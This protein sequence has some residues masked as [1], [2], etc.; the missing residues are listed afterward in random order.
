MTLV[1]VLAVVI[2]LGLIA[3]TLVVGLGGRFGQARQEIAR[4]QIA[5]LRAQVELF[6]I[7]TK[8]LPSGSEGL[9]V[10]TRN[11]QSA[12]FIEPSQ[13]IDPW[14]N[15]L[16]YVVPGPDGRAFEIK[17]Y[18]ADGS[19]GGEGENADISSAA[20]AASNDP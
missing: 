11:P 8:R 5:S 9:E 1:E 6:Q 15:P 14:G 19:V 13:I 12:Y 10:L 4:S 17:S 2:I 7:T 3:T 16:Y 20:L 18:G